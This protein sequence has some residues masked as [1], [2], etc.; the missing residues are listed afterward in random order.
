MRTFWKILFV[1]VI[2]FILALSV[3][4]MICEK[5]ASSFLSEY[6]SGKL[7]VAVKVEDISFSWNQIKIK[8]FEIDN[9][10]GSILPKAFTAQTILIKTPL[11]NFLK[12]DVV[13]NHIIVDD[14]TIG[15]EFD[16]I[17][18]ANGNWTRL[19]GNLYSS[20]SPSQGTEAN[21]SVTI[22]KISLQQIKAQVVYKTDPQ[23]IIALP[24]VKYEEF[25]NISS[26]GGIP[27]DQI[28]N[29]VLGKMLISLFAREHLNNMFQQFLN[30]ENAIKD[31]VAPFKML[32]P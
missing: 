28:M 22:K 16:N 26:K 12:N 14:I 2:L 3:A 19:I 31:L 5:R 17:K 25:T 24:V 7:K 9:V 29:S 27:I 1:V 15:L 18:S 8:G 32:I 30:P 6:L 13:I 10:K 21:R 23:K 4:T 11:I 20:I